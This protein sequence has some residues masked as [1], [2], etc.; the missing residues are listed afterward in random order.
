[1]T[2]I[3]VTWKA[4]DNKDPK[5]LQDFADAG[6]VP[7]T[8]TTIETKIGENLNPFSV[9][10]MVFHSTNTYQGDLW[11]ALQPLPEDRTHTALCV[12]DEV[13]IDGQT[14]RCDD[15]GFSEVAELDTALVN[16]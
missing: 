15:F 4:F 12:G 6:R 10:E 11:D 1:M 2:R 13:T 5:R 3:T 14:Y 9:C 16:N 8:S 7:V